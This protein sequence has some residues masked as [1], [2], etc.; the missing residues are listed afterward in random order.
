MPSCSEAW[1]ANYEKLLV[2]KN[3]FGH[4]KVAPLHDQSLYQWTVLQCKKRHEMNPNLEEWMIDKLN[5]IGFQWKIQPSS[6]CLHTKKINEAKRKMKDNSLN[7][8][9]VSKKT[10]L[11]VAAV[12]TEVTAVD[13]NLS[14]KPKIVNNHL[15]EVDNN[16]NLTIV[17]ID[18]RESIECNNHGIQKRSSINTLERK[19]A[20]AAAAAAIILEE[21]GVTSESKVMTAEKARTGSDGISTT[22]SDAQKRSSIKTLDERKSISA[23]AAAVAA[24]EDSSNCNFSANNASGVLKRSSIKTLDEKKAVAAAG[25]V[26]ADLEDNNCTLSA[27]ADVAQKRSSIKTLDEKKSVAAA[28]AVLSMEYNDYEENSGLG[29]QKDSSIKTLDDKQSVST[30]FPED[31]VLSESKVGH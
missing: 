17:S 19:K 30:A 26:V 22:N 24:L 29:I 16:G 18:E 8:P 25:A 12:T 10:K 27:N 3:E 7:I 13:D 15:M 20:A 11:E 21:E 9:S 1:N 14:S 23:V 4:V 2:Y 31:R 28:A 5:E 6:T